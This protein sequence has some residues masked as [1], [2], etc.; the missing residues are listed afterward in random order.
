MSREP[1]ERGSSGV[2]KEEP[3]RHGKPS[4]D[5]DVG[6]TEKAVK[7]IP[8][9]NLD[10][11]LGAVKDSFAEG[12]GEA[13]SGAENLI[14]IGVVVDIAA[15]VVHVEAQLIGK[16]LCGP[17][18]DVVAVRGF[19]RQPQHVRIERDHLLRTGE[20]NVLERRSLENSVVRSMDNQAG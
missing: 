13:D 5:H 6:I 7:A 3:A 8:V 11:S 19:H 12:N 16:I 14:V 1:A 2:A 20:Q 10:L 18:F 15:E 9:W 17:H 4:I